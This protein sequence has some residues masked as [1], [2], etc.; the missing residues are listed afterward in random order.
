MSVADRG[1]GISA[2]EQARVFERFHQA[3]DSL[4]REAEGAGLGLYITKRL[5]EAMDGTIDVRSEL[6]HGSTFTVRLPLM[7]PGVFPLSG[8][9]PISVESR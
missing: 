6:G 7:E 2:E 3:Q 1:V 4:T 9:E 8:G 5:V